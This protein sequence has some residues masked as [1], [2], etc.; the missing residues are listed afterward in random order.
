MVCGFL[1][2]RLRRIPLKF[3]DSEKDIIALYTSLQLI[4]VD[5]K[6][7]DMCHQILN[8]TNAKHMWDIVELIMEGLDEVKENWLD[9]LTSQYEAFNSL[10]TE[11]H[12]SS[13]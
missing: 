4:I 10:P 12:N 6:D 13:I 1:K 8:C 7:S 11:N 9:I 2:G 5:S 3:T